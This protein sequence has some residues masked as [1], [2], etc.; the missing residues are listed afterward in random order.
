MF[1]HVLIQ[2]PFPTGFRLIPGNTVMCPFF[3]TVDKRTDIW[4]YG[5]CFSPP[6]GHLK[7]GYLSQKKV[8]F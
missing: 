5:F 3:S 2:L 1:L 7:T 6:R 4:K 8:V